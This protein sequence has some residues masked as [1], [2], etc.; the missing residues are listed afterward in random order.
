LTL[1]FSTLIKKDSI[2]PPIGGGGENA[3]ARGVGVEPLRDT[4]SLIGL[5]VQIEMTVASSPSNDDGS[6]RGAE[7]AFAGISWRGRAGDRGPTS[8]R[9]ESLVRNIR[10]R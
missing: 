9:C 1:I 6:L 8:T 10:Q 5:R 4:T 2:A 7:V 3:C